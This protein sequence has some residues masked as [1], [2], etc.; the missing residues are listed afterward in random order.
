[1]QLM[2]CPGM[3]EA[4]IGSYVNEQGISVP[5]YD[6]QAV[7]DVFARQNK[8]A[9]TAVDWMAEIIDTWDE[10]IRPIFID[11]NPRLAKVAKKQKG[12]QH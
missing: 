12:Y 8:D 9:D 4:I 10:N 1:M 3:D 7:I 5:V 2:V 11:Y 6:V